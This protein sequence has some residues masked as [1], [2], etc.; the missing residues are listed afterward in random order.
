MNV[1]TLLVLFLLPTPL[2]VSFALW[3]KDMRV[4]LHGTEEL[5]KII[6]SECKWL[7]TH[8]YFISNDRLYKVTTISSVLTCYCM[9]GVMRVKIYKDRATCI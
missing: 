2:Y 6:G 9:G 5:V 3:L 7:I 1:I 8:L 4:H